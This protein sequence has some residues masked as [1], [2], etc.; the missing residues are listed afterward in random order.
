MR[1]SG[2]QESA[3]PLTSRAV[4]AGQTLVITARGKAVA[5]LSPTGEEKSD[6]NSLRER[7]EALQARGL[8]RLG[9]GRLAKFPP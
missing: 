9:R 2:V 6:L 7:L 5:K 4:R 8:I 3:E 1:Y